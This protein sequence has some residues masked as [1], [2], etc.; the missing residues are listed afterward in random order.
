MRC[1]EVMKKDVCSVTP[2]DTC[3][4]AAAIM[5]D[6][7]I[8]FLPVCSHDGQVLGTLTDRDLAI[9]VLAEGLGPD[10]E[11]NDVMTWEVIACRPEDDLTRA[12]ELFGEARKSRIMCVDDGNHLVG[13][14]S[15]SD[16]AFRAETD[17]MLA[18]TFRE[19][20]SREAMPD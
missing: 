8:G 1:E 3:G 17:G 10:T 9:R 14:I 20:T 4:E 5:R 12:V 15:L 2:A 13:V 19:V 6:E 18:R 7:N 11:V 16:L